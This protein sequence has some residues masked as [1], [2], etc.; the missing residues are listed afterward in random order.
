MNLL[1]RFLLVPGRLRHR[2]KNRNRLV[3][4][5]GLITTLKKQCE[6]AHKNGFKSHVV[7]YNAALFIALVEQ[8][9][10]AY[11]SALY[12]ANTKWHQQFAARGMAVLLYE[13]AKDIPEILGKEYRQALRD[14]ELGDAWLQALNKGVTGFNTFKTEHASFLNS[15]RT[16]VGAHKEK[17]ALAQLAVLE[18]LDHMEIYR[19][20]AKFS[21]SLN[22]LVE[23][24]MAL[25]IYL[26]NPMVMLKEGGKAVDRANPALQGTLRDEA[27]LRPDLER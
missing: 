2:W 9:L 12:F 13:T 6:D 14:L 18:A 20:G 3:V 22:S 17:D 23:F 16:Y 27:A 19:L 8:N 1:L 7:A 5:T 25:L 4:T 24:Q 15:V 26:K 21:A 10:S 11:S